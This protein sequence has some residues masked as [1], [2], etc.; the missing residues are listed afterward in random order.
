MVV[1][2]EFRG[3]IIPICVIGSAETATDV[4]LVAIHRVGE[5]SWAFINFLIVTIDRFPMVR[6]RGWLIVAVSGFRVVGLTV[7][8][9][10]IVTATITA[11]VITVLIFIPSVIFIVIVLTVIVV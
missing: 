11:T 5:V 4:I 2:V 3:Q 8:V 7:E 9:V 10:V 1:V 6:L